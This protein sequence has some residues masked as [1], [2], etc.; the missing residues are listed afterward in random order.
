MNDCFALLDEPRRPW[1]DPEAL[2][3]KFLSLSARLHPD[4][5][6]NAGEAEKTA[7]QQRYLELNAAY[8]RLRDPK[9]R[10]L[11]LLELEQGAKPS[12]VQNIPSAL[13]PLFTRVNE[14]CR[15]ADGILKEMRDTMSP[16]LRVQLFET[17]QQSSEQLL[18]LQ[19]QL[20]G[21]Q[22]QLLGEIRQIDLV[23]DKQEDRH[24]I[25][26]RLEEI[27][28]LL[29]YFGRWSGQVQERVA[30]LAMAGISF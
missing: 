1:I 4:R 19:G 7:A 29:S 23:W 15:A 18:E 16:L 14:T 20:N 11:H 24:A 9:Q 22:D 30:Q 21:E 8:N 27:Y 13:I 26:A 10:L 3:N 2:K 6:H 25:L 12:D 17:S 5:V 28:R